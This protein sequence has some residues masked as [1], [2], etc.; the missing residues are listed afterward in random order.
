MAIFK[1]VL[2]SDLRKKVADVVF[3]KSNSNKI[4]RSNPGKIKN[5]RTLEQRT[6]RAKMAFLVDLSRR[7]LS[8]ISV[9]FLERPSGSSIYNAFVKANMPL[10]TV[11]DK[12]QASIDYTKL[13]C[14]NGVKEYPDVSA[15]FAEDTITVIQTEQKSTGSGTFDDMVYAGFY[16]S[17]LRSARLVQI[18]ERE[19]TTSVEFPLPKGWIKENIYV[20]AF[21]LSQS[22]KHTSSTLYVVLS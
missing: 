9:G 6:Q 15:T 11:D 20:Y 3:Y 17:A 5:P 12:L 22:R 18:G 2:F 21:A 10:V 16:E 4:L 13:L 7:L 19:K 14:S 8:I 1:S